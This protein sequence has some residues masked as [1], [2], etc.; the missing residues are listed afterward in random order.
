MSLGF[1]VKPWSGN[2]RA[3]LERSSDISNVIPVYALSFGD[4][5]R[6][7]RLYALRK[8]IVHGLFCQAPI[9]GDLLFVFGAL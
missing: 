7:Q 6:D 4:E 8:Q 5:L 1:T 2:E 3:V 9:A